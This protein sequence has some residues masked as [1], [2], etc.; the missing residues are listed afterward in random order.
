MAGAEEMSLR[1]Q[2]VSGRGEGGRWIVYDHRLI[3]NGKAQFLFKYLTENAIC[4]L[5]ESSK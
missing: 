4:F 1:E 3:E 5:K 2:E